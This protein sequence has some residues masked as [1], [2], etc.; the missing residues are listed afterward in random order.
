MERGQKVRR[1]CSTYNIKVTLEQKLK[2]YFKR[3]QLPI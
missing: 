2:I 3:N 1:M